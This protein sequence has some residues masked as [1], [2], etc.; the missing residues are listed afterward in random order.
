MIESLTNWFKRRLAW[1]RIWCQLEELSWLCK[2]GRTD[3]DSRHLPDFKSLE[4]WVLL[5]HES[6]HA[7]NL[8]ETVD[9]LE[10]ANRAFERMTAQRK[11]VLW[12]ASAAL[13]KE[14]YFMRVANLCQ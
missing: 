13:R 9:A 6:Y 8:T 7:S 5:A 2:G 11:A 14:E 10:M 12:L 1:H 4:A 3:A